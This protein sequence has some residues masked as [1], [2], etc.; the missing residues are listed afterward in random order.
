MFRT[1]AGAGPALAS[2]LTAGRRDR[3]AKDIARGKGRGERCGRDSLFETS[4]RFRSRRHPSTSS[5]SSRSRHLSIRAM[6]LTSLLAVASSA[7][8][9]SASGLRLQQATV[10]VIS[11]EGS[12]LASHSCVHSSCTTQ[13]F[14]GML[15]GL[16]D[17][18]NRLPERRL[19]A[20]RAASP[21]DHQARL[22]D[23]RRRVR[24][25]RHSSP[26][27]SQLR[28]VSCS[29]TSSVVRA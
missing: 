28:R 15:K 6:L 5:T 23:P 19:L 1:W 11:S 24:R 3:A 9:A 27:P 10:S 26:D 13:C 18:Q 12:T 29:F 17:M 8:L 16:S 21:F 2:W 25:G 7:L 20:I 4:R 14:D 22:P